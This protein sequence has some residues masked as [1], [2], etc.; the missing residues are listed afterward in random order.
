MLPRPEEAGGS[1]TPAI[2]FDPVSHCQPRQRTYSRHRELQS[3]V[4]ESGSDTCFQDPLGGKIDARPAAARNVLVAM[5]TPPAISSLEEEI[6]VLR[7]EKAKL[8]DDCTEKQAEI[9]KLTQDIEN[10]NDH[11]KRRN[12]AF[13]A[14]EADHAR[15]KKR[16]TSKDAEMRESKEVYENQIKWFENQAKEHQVVLHNTEVEL[17]KSAAETQGLRVTVQE[18][19]DERTGADE[20][21][22]RLKERLKDLQSM[23]ERLQAEK[24]RIIADQE[25]TALVSGGRDRNLNDELAELN[26]LDER[27][28]FSPENPQREWANEQLDDQDDLLPQLGEAKQRPFSFTERD[29]RQ[30]LDEDVFTRMSF[31]SISSVAQAPQPKT[32]KEEPKLDHETSVQPGITSDPAGEQTEHAPQDP[33]PEQPK[34]E[35]RR[36]S[37]T[38]LRLTFPVSLPSHLSPSTLTK[39]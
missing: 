30:D 6:A 36:Q 10:W 31:S 37:N 35:K 21:I 3:S 33:L 18:L 16:L 5:A 25:A 1:D 11:D 12:A 19:E 22:T 27:G 34:P 32:I 28:N 20:E 39:Y 24:A 4:R 29:S 9:E 2:G 38:G 26:E 8:E 15:D 14:K 17:T 13:E 7:R 23:N